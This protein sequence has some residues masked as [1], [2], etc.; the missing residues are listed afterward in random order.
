MKK[1]LSFFVITMFLS[2]AVPTRWGIVLA[3]TPKIT[4]SKPV[5]LV[6]GNKQYQYGVLKN[7]VNDATDIARVLKEIGFEVILKTNLNQRAMDNALRL[8]GRRL[9]K[10][11]SVGFF[12]FSGHGARVAGENYLL[13]IDNNRIQDERDLQYYAIHATKVLD[14]M[15]N[16]RN[17]LNIIVLDAC[18][19]NPYRSFSRSINR[20]LTRM[21]I[22]KGS[23]IAF[24]TAPNQ[25]ASDTSKNRRNGLFTSH[26]IKGLKKAHQ[27]CQRVDDMFMDVS[28][29][30]MLESGGRQEPWQLASLKKPVYFGSCQNLAS[31]TRQ[32][33]VV[34]KQKQPVTIFRDR[35][36][37][38]SQGPEMVM[39]PTGQFQM[40]DIQGG[41]DSD[42]KP[43][44]L[45]SVAQFAISRYEITVS[46]YLRF[47]HATGRH[48][49]EWQKAGSKYNIQTGTRGYYYNKLGSALT[50]ENH[51]IVGVSWYNAVAYADW[52]S[53]QTG[54]PYRLPTEA[55]WEYAARAGKK[56]KYWWGNKIGFK[57]ANCSNRDCGDDFKYTAPVGSFAS[58]P[59]Q[60]YNTVGNVWEWTCSEYED[61]Y[62]GKEQQCKAK[63]DAKNRR[64]VLRGGSWDNGARGG[65]SANRV[66]RRPYERGV[67][68]GFRLAK[69]YK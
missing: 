35:L 67:S 5:A 24:A 33:R 13:P 38:G 39:I 8:F 62:S 37:N 58:N 2:V 41:G 10:N 54:K 51:P 30:V 66:W 18:R 65:R 50:K 19:D 4:A 57:K 64:F 63:N 60:L 25:T 69:D 9:S 61:K 26:L 21:A 17:N 3:A 15:Q 42:E 68:I 46:E 44:H 55:E 31:F 28:N 16:A 53:Q 7:T 23:I 47:V 49:P 27:N 40:G 12:Y 32:P 34:S 22:A 45:V 48:A 59:F 56:T 43:V 1:I 6:I 36:K 14:I 11:N 29:A 20:G 52:L